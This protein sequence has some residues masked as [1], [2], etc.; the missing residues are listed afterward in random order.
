VWDYVHR[1]MP[2]SQPG[3]LTPDEV[4]SVTA[5]LL[6]M[7]GIASEDA[8]LDRESLPRIR[9]PNRDGFTSD[10]RRNTDGQAR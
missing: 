4:Y 5:Y 1:A 6:F 10:G 2:Y 8:L 7:N 3:Y 9:M